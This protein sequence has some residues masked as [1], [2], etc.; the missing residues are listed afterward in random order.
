MSETSLSS[1]TPIDVVAGPVDGLTEVRSAKP[2]LSFTQIAMFLR[3]PRQYASRYV[4]GRKVPPSGAMIQGKVWHQTVERNYRQKIES[5]R[6]LGLP[7][8]QGF[9]AE[10]FDSALT[11]EEV[12][13]DSGDTPAKLKDQGV[14]IVAAHH[15][16]IAPAVRPLLVE[17]PFNLD[18]G[19]AFPFTLMGV[20][21]L[22]ERDGTIVDNKSYSKT[23][24]QADL[25]KDLQF[26]AYALAYRATRQAIEPGLRMDA[27]IKTKTPKAIQLRTQ[28]T[29]DQCR[30][31]LRLIE[32]VG[33]AIHSGN[34][35]P[36]P[37]GW[38]CSPRFCGYWSRCMGS[39]QGGD[40]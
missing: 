16:A 23:P 12:A 1:P 18:L 40:A 24:S 31:L 28:R 26:T 7:E 19:E 14:A 9:F 15:K 37:I 5:D 32:Q 8:M 38:H 3:C 10:R 39:M 36:N 34:F 27:I 20:W 17:E 11:E 30:W 29:N 13:F 6:D 35:Y 22:V 4:E 33:A 2:H 21:D 25:D